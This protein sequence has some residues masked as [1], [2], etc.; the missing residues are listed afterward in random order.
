MNYKGRKNALLLT[1][2]AFMTSCL[3]IGIY[4]LADHSS[5]NKKVDSDENSSIALFFSGLGGVLVLAS[6][7]QILSSS[8]EHSSFKSKS[9]HSLRR[10]A[11]EPD[12]SLVAALGAFLLVGS[13]TTIYGATQVLPSVIAYSTG[14]GI[15]VLLFVLLSGYTLNHAP[16]VKW[17]SILWLVVITTYASFFTYY[18]NLA[19]RQLEK[20]ARERAIS[21]HESLMSEVFVPLKLELRQLDNSIA[22]LDSADEL[23]MSGGEP[24][25]AGCGSICRENKQKREKLKAE[26]SEVKAILDSVESSFLNGNIEDKEPSE[27]FRADLDVLTEIPLEYLP[28]EY[29]LRRD[30]QSLT[31]STFRQKYISPSMDTHLLIPFQE[32]MQGDPSAVSAGVLAFSLNGVI[33]LLGIAVNAN[34]R[35]EKV[36]VITE[37]ITGEEFLNNIL[38]AI[39]SRNL[40]V[41]L[42]YFD[43]FK[44]AQS[45]LRF[46]AIVGSHT[47]WLYR[48]K[49]SQQSEMNIA[50]IS[51]YQQFTEWLN[52]EREKQVETRHRRDILA[53]LGLRLFIYWF[54]I[55]R[56]SSSTFDLP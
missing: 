23:E 14:I 27:I 37:N 3:L 56:K 41:N 2:L 8:N 10:K 7:R 18:E 11:R 47:E 26:Q 24:G 20:Y 1:A 13:G 6:A 33:L 19:D 49:S 31:Y 4:V 50:S 5:S 48:D 28:E 34:N 42:D 15:H 43:R 35:P 17:I 29:A 36:T 40:A 44:N 32:I 9:E 12:I 53:K 51:A 16:L 45:Y 55:G 22:A 38:D 46:L 39:D 52:K 21:A 25:V 54:S 30:A